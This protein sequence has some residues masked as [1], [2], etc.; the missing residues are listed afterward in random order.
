MIRPG[1]VFGRRRTAHSPLFQSVKKMC[2]LN[3]CAPQDEG[4]VRSECVRVER[5]ETGDLAPLRVQVAQQLAG[6]VHHPESPVVGAD[7][8][9]VV[10]DPQVVR[11]GFRHLVAGHLPG[12][13][14]SL[15]SMT[16]IQ[17]AAMIGVPPRPRLR[18]RVRERL[19]AR[20][21]VALA[22]RRTRVRERRVIPLAGIGIAPQFHRPLRR[23]AAAR[24]PRRQPQPPRQSNWT[25][26]RCRRS[27]R[28]HEY[29]AERIDLELP[30]APRFGRVLDTDDLIA[31]ARRSTRTRAPRI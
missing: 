19:V 27:P 24:R 14:Q 7:V 25:R 23:P 29:C 4:G 5:Q 1:P 8:Q 10:L 9:R 31:P 22:C 18:A 15:Q 11:P 16:C 26:R 2:P 30:D 13:L 12:M 17:P 20:E 28:R 21:Q 6:H 3:G